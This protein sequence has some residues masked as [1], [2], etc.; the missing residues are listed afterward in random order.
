MIIPFIAIFVMVT[1]VE[2]DR[3]SKMVLT[4]IDSVIDY[5]VFSRSAARI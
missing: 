4:M 2:R 5:F 1:F 3:L